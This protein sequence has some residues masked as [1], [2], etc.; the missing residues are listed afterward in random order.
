MG[1]SFHMRAQKLIQK[2]NGEAG[3]RTTGPTGL[4]SEVS[5]PHD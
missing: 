3:I 5:K 2:E 1:P 4:L